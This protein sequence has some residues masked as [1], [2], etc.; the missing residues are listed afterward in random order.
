MHLPIVRRGYVVPNERTAPDESVSRKPPRSSLLPRMLNL[1]KVGGDNHSLCQGKV[2]YSAPARG[3]ASV[4]LEMGQSTTV[5]AGL[6]GAE[7]SVNAQ[8]H[9]VRESSDGALL[10]A[11][12]RKGLE[13]AP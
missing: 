6:L 1:P 3:R 12:M 2:P 7:S 5:G 11:M 9:M 10:V 4:T 13:S 8:N